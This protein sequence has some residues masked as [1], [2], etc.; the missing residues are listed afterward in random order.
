MFVPFF[1]QPEADLVIEM[2]ERG[3]IVCHQES[4]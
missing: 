4:R 1:F 2:S 3:P